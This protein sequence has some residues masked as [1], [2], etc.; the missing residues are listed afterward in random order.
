M[1]FI[2]SCLLLSPGDEIGMDDLGHGV[3]HDVHVDQL[4]EVEVNLETD[5]GNVIQSTTFEPYYLPRHSRR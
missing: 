4:R 3:Q 5:L 1:I 2:N